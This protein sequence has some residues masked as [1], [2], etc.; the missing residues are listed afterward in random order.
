MKIKG[1]KKFSELGSSNNWASFG[2]EVFIKLEAGESVE[3][4]NFDKSLMEDG[5]VESVTE[6][7]KKYTLCIYRWIRNTDR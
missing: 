5:F 1:T 6:T 2:K 7:K 4:K 3:V